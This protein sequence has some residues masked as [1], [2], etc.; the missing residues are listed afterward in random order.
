MFG[1]SSAEFAVI[2]MMAL[3]VV[4]PKQMPGV[5][6]TFGRAYRKLNHFI[7]NAS[8][9]ID[10]TLYDADRIA[11]KAEKY[12]LDDQQKQASRQKEKP[13]DDK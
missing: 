11:E 3:L 5:L 7:K 8:Q 2:L 12:L 13:V 6:R 10:D 9:V 4:G 1:I